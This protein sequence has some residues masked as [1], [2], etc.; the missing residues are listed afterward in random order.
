[1]HHHQAFHQYFVISM[2]LKEKSYEKAVRLL[3]NWRS[4]LKARFAISLEFIFP[5]LGVLSLRPFGWSWLSIWVSG[6]I[7]K[8]CLSESC[9]N[10]NYSFPVKI[11]DR[12]IPKTMIDFCRTLREVLARSLANYHEYSMKTCR[13]LLCKTSKEILSRFFV[14]P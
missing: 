5:I 4:S 3:H 2:E 6:R 8:I 7:L 10:N 14:K 1:M 13:K 11:F 9:L 12:S